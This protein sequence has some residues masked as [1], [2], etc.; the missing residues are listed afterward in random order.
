MD[1]HAPAH[2][3]GAGRTRSKNHPAESPGAGIEVS[4]GAIV[5]YIARRWA[6]RRSWSRRSNS[7]DLIVGDETSIAS[8]ITLCEFASCSATAWTC[9][10]GRIAAFS[11]LGPL[12]A[13][14]ALEELVRQ[15]A[16]RRR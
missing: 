1:L 12:V 2:R 16:W 6:S 7:S 14:G 15:L 13:V 10:R 11:V 9:V 4:Q 3:M 8:S 5:D